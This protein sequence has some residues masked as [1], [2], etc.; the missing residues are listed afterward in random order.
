MFDETKKCCIHQEYIKFL[1]RKEQ[2]RVEA[3]KKRKEEIVR[4]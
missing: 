3:E 4:R 2:E 1:K